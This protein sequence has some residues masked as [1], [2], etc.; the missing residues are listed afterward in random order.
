MKKKCPVLM[1]RKWPQ[2]REEINNNG[3]SRERKSS[4]KEGLGIH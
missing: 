4:K 2:T 1:V 3:G